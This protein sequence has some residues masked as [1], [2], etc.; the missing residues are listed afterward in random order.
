MY[1][2]SKRLVFCD[3]RAQAEQLAVALRGHGVET[4]LS[5]SSLSAGTRRQ[6]EAAFAQAANCVI[7]ATSTLELGI[8]IGDLD[9]VI[10]IDAP[11]TVASF[12]QRL[13]RTGRRP[14]TARNA[15]IVT[16][17]PESLWS[18]AALLL[19]WR[20]GYV[21]P[22]VPPALPRHIVAQQLL[23]LALQEHRIVPS[24]LNGWLGGIA[25]VPGADQVLAHL[26]AEGFLAEDGG[27]LFIGPKAEQE[28]GR[29][30]YRDLTSAFTSE[31]SFTAIYGRDIIGELPV[32]T[33]AV[34]PAAG[35][36]VV[37]LGGRSW[38][39][40]HVDWRSRRVAVEPSESP[41][42]TRWAGEG[43]AMPHELARAHHDVLTGR[44]PEVG[45]SRRAQAGLAELRNEYPFAVGDD[46]FRT[47]L[48]HRPKESPEWWTFAGQAANRSLTA[49]LGDL[50]D[51]A[52]AD[53]PLRLRLQSE[54]SV[55]KLR[56][57]ITDRQDDLVSTAP[58]VDDRVAE[59][60]KFSAAIP[61]TL[62][63][64]TLS[65]RLADPSAVRATIKAGMQSIH[66]PEK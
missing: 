23:G 6:T 39:V 57:A 20:R 38:V 19:L 10:Q 7:V 47:Y 1:Q 51:Q 32:L 27:L 54:V 12:L 5:H 28:F 59:A 43:R 24:D 55:D 50:V 49:G 44:N 14:G 26:T 3:S 40:R 2:G 64:E 56:K 45:L 25:A 46:T 8:D 37:L 11:A 22:V 13:G 4:Y 16:T 42:S 9:H 31:P 53:G 35:R 33:L 17:R 18:A 30:F 21:E 29:R 34:R 48:V 66:F 15:L 62:A 41:G 61:L 52:T 63:V 65:A 36:R 60:L 58:E